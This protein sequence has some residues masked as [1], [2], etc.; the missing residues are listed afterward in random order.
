[1]HGGLSITEV[2]SV[3]SVMKVHIF[4]PAYKCPFSDR[5]LITA[6]MLH[7][8]VSYVDSSVSRITTKRN[9]KMLDM[10]AFRRNLLL[11]D[12]ITDPIVDCD[13]FFDAYDDCLRTLID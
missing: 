4:L 13:H 6:V 12:V 2:A 5:S 3:K 8:D 10:A 11:S 7:R 9:W 1:M